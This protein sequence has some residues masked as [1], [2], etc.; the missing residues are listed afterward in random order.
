[1]KSSIE[2]NQRIF[3][4]LSELDW[5]SEITVE[6]HNGC[7]ERMI[8]DGYCLVPPG[9]DPEEVGYLSGAMP[10]KHPRNQFNGLVSVSFKDLKAIFGAN[11]RQIWPFPDGFPKSHKSLK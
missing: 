10:K 3:N 1:M 9:D 4:E 11:G 7:S 5:P 2:S 8:G 6:T